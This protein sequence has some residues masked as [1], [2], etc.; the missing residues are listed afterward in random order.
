MRPGIELV[1]SWVLVEFVIAEP[2]Q[3]IW[4]NI[5]FLFY[6]IFCFL[7]LHPWYMEVPRLGVESEL[8]LPSYTTATAMWDLSHFCDL[9]H[10]SRQW[11]ILNPLSEA[12]D[13]T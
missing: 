12:R 2:Q 1:F 3:E 10:S 4:I 11:Q 9:Y 13:R 8:Q 6:F 5:L 7:G